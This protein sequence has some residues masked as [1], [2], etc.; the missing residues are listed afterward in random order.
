LSALL[1]WRS[2]YEGFMAYVPVLR[3]PLRAV[4]LGWRPQQTQAH[5]VG[6]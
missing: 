1:E 6:T 2:G 3:D 4:A 5:P